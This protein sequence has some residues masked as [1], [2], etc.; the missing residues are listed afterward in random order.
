MVGRWGQ[1]YIVLAIGLVVVQECS[2]FLFYLCC[3]FIS[4]EIYLDIV[5]VEVFLFVGGCLGGFQVDQLWFYGQGVKGCGLYWG[6]CCLFDVEDFVGLCLQIQIVQ[7]YFWF[8]WWVVWF[9]FWFVW[10]I[11]FVWIFI[12]QVVFCVFV[13][14]EEFVFVV[15]VFVGGIKV[16]CVG[17]QDVFQVG[18]VFDFWEYVEQKCCIV[19]CKWCG[20]VGVVVGVYFFFFWLVVEVGYVVVYVVYVSVMVVEGSN[21]VVVVYCVDS[22]QDFVQVVGVDVVGEVYVVVV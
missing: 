19:Y 20:V 7:G 5:Q 8:W 9:V 17:G 21:L 12:G 10:F 3:S 15:V 4:F 1:E 11:W 6:Y 2:K 13:Y 14:V 16:G 22:E 18:Y